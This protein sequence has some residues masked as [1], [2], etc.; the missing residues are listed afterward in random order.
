MVGWLLVVGCGW[1]PAASDEVPPEA[2]PARTALDTVTAE[3][4]RVVDGPWVDGLQVAWVSGGKL[5]TVRLGTL[6]AVDGGLE[7]GPVSEMVTGLLLAE[8]ATRG[9]TLPVDE[10]MV[11]AVTA[12]EQQ[13]GSTWS[14]LFDEWVAG[15]KG[16]ANTGAAAPGP[17]GHV[18]TGGG[19]PR[20]EWTETGP[21]E[22]VTSS[23]DDLGV[24]LLEALAAPEG[25]GGMG[26]PC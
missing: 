16:L 5:E 25:A 1:G 10:G 8:A 26:D 4:E 21:V 3:L 7:L 2:E 18:P 22:A 20:L 11:E 9:H 14:A 6:G 24:L 15:P 12:L 17:V 23:I 19:A 13:T